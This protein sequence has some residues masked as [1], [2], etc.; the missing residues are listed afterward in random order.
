VAEFPM[1]RSAHV[2][3]EHVG[4]QLHAVADAEHGGAELEER[5]VETRRARLGDAA[6]TAGEDDPGRLPGAQPLERRIE[7]HDLR[8][9][10]QLAQPSRDQLR[11]LRAEIQDEN[12]LMHGRNAGSCERLL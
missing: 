3:A 9:D 2:A 7:G 11:V 6:R 10:R 8:I 5:R 4:H 12:G 1:P